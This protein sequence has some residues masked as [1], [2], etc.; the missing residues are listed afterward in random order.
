MSHIVLKALLCIGILWFSEAGRIRHREFSQLTQ[1]QPI[2]AH[3]SIKVTALWNISGDFLQYE[4]PAAVFPSTNSVL[5]VNA[6]RPSLLNA[7]L[8]SINVH[9]G[10]V[11]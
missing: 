4:F 7:T 11:D 1:S 5:C 10:N 6:S 3:P 2:I 9:T 8:Q